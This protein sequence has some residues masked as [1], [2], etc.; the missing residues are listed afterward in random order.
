MF[1]V[2]FIV[3]VSAALGAILQGVTS[4]MDYEVGLALFV[5]LGIGAGL[6]VLA[7]WHA[8]PR[9]PQDG[10]GRPPER[11]KGPDTSPDENAAPGGASEPTDEREDGP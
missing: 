1:A 6:W 11:D 10:P 9:P 5:A 2:A 8:A 7:E 3:L 4:P